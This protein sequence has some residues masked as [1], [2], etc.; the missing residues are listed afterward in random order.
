[1]VIMALAWSS[2]MSA[3]RRGLSSS[4]ASCRLL[5][6]GLI[7]C[8]VS[9]LEAREG[10]YLAGLVFFLGIRIDHIFVAEGDACMVKENLPGVCQTSSKCEPRI[11]KYIKTGKL[12]VDK[13]PSCGLGPYE[14]I[15]CCPTIDCCEEDKG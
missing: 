6:C 14:E 4:L 15:V 3:R 8:A 5:L 11:D 10:L 9:D 7:L 2:K 12:T 1:M 13:V